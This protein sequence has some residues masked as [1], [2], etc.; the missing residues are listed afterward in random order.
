[1]SNFMGKWYVLLGCFA[2]VACRS[3]SAT[4][5]QKMFDKIHALG[6]K[7]CFDRSSNWFW[8]VLGSKYN[9]TWHFMGIHYVFSMCWPLWPLAHDLALNGPIYYK[10]SLISS[11]NSISFPLE[12]ALEGRFVLRLGWTWQSKGMRYGFS[13]DFSFVAVWSRSVHDL[14]YRWRQRKFRW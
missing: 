10:S 14:S 6:Q 3:R 4:I 5:W 7:W 8:I 1:M 12:S 11:K 9:S 2:F 13:T